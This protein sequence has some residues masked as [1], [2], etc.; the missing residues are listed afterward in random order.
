MVISMAD[1]LSGLRCSRPP[2]R[3]LGVDEHCSSLC[4]RR[5]VNEGTVE[6][7]KGTVVVLLVELLLVMI[8]GATIMATTIIVS[9]VV[10]GHSRRGESHQHNHHHGHFP[11]N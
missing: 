8:H 11:K 9:T 7:V 6:P 4:Q 1:V 5:G 2:V 3:R 10:F